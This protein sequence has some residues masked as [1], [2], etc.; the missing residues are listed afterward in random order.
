VWGY[1]F[2][3]PGMFD[4]TTDALPDFRGVVEVQAL[5]V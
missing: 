5:G 4:Y 2:T 3:D 1:E